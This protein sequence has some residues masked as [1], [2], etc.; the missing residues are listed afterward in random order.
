MKIRV[1]VGILAAAVV[2]ASIWIHAWVFTGLIVLCSFVAL[3]EIRQAFA[4]KDIRLIYLPLVL[5]AALM[6]PAYYFLDFQGL[7]VLTLLCG[8]LCMASVVASKRVRIQDAFFTSGTLLYPLLPISICL[9][10]SLIQPDGLRYY[11]LIQ[12]LACTYLADTFALFTGMLLGKHKL[13]ERLS[14]KKTVE[15]LLGGIV[16][17]MLG[18]LLCHFLL[19]GLWNVSFHVAH[20]LIIGMACALLGVMGDLSA[21]AIKRYAEVKDFGSLLPGHGGMLDRID[22]LLFTLPFVFI[23]YQVIV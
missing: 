8:L 11:I 17:S 1:V 22:S 20:A 10:A 13:C 23:Y 19:G 2:L 3:Y 21:S 9:A 14:P 7:L 6:T 16:G 18:G 15:G 5:Y 12:A 4:R